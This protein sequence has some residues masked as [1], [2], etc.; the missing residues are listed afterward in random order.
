MRT[1]TTLAA[2]AILAAGLASSMAQANV[3]SLNIVGYYNVPL[4]GL[5][6]L[7]NSLSTGTP[8]DRMDQVIPYSDGNNIQLWTGSSWS[9][10]T[11]DS[12]SSSGWTDNSGA[13]IAVANLPLLSAGKGFFYGNNNG[14]T[15][16]TFVGDVRTGTNIVSLAVGLDASGSPLPYGGPGPEGKVSTGPLNL[17][18]GD[19]DNI[20]KWTG[21]SWNVYTRDSGEPTGWTDPTGAGGPEPT[22]NVG[23]GFFY[24]NNTVPNTWTQILNNP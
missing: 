1:K 18:V 3:Y 22:L 24:G 2:A 9:I 14:A 15:N 13:D 21:T 10:Y 4:G 23:Q 19:G 16:I 7:A 11:M 6:A 12:G 5:T 17:Q 20:Q 8:K